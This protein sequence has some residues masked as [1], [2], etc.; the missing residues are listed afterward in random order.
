M[1]ISPR[2]L[3]P[4][5]VMIV[6]AVGLTACG[7]DSK[8]STSSESSS[9]KATSSSTAPTGDIVIKGAKVGDLGT[10]LVD[11]DGRTVYTLTKDGA[12]VACTGGCLQAWPPVLLPAGSTTATGGSGVSG[13]GVVT[14]TDGKQVTSKDLPLY[15]FSGDPAAGDANGEGLASFGG[16]WH[17]V[18]VGGGAASTQTSTTT[19]GNGYG[20]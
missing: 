12:N 4:M 7:S 1:K 19:T 9:T 13:L 17:V 2:T 8:S 15:T 18:K 6:A 3:A 14:V 20:Y 10:I 11:A 16:V 5:A